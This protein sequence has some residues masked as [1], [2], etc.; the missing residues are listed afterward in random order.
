MQYL[1][2]ASKMTE[3]SVYFQGKL[4]NITVIQVYAPITN[5]REEVEQF[6]ED[7]QDF[8]ELTHTKKDVLFIIRESEKC[9]HSEIIEKWFFKPIWNV[10]LAQSPHF[11]TTSFPGGSIGKE[12]G[13]NTGDSRQCRRPG[14]SSLEKEMATHSNILVWEIPWTEE[15]GRLQSMGLKELDMT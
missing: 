14:F 3:W 9:S 13:Y 8:P 12:S 2:A 4:F 11:K 10:F 7:L 1:G 6:Y 15:C 5:A